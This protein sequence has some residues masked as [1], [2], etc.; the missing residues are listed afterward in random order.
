MAKAI[1]RFY[2]ELNDF[3]PKHRRKK[4]FEAQFEGKRSV[5]DM[6][7]ALGVPHAEIDLIPTKSRKLLKF[8]EVTHGILIR[9]GTTAQQ[10]KKIIEH[11]DIGM[12]GQ[13][14][15]KAEVEKEI[16]S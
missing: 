3:L 7:E 11:L 16:K 1:F 14:K 15:V 8:R 13:K 5:K 2:E 12:G 9:P 10:V 4:D 6:F